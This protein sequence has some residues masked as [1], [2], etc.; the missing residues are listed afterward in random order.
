MKLP[1]NH[2]TLWI[3]TIFALMVAVLDFSA[4]A[5]VGGAF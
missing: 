2:R 1:L 4:R 5:V 3:T